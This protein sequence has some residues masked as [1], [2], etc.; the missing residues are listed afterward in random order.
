M[1]CN[2]LL[3]RVVALVLTLV[4]AASLGCEGSDWKQKQTPKAKSV[5]EW[6]GWQVSIA[7]VVRRGDHLLLS[8]K[9]RAETH[10]WHKN[11]AFATVVFWDVSGGRL[12][13][14]REVRFDFPDDWFDKLPNEFTTKFDL[15]YPEGAKECAIQVFDNDELTTNRVSI[16]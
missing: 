16:P 14:E 6:R 11:Y 2:N 7:S 9:I 3:T 5:V 13:V 12:P 4:F 15:E 8:Y 10:M 1:T